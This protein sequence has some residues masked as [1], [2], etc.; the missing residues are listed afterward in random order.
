MGLWLG[1]GPSHTK[2]LEA[3]A[4]SLDT[5]LPSTLSSALSPGSVL[6]LSESLFPSLSLNESHLWSPVSL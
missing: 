2:W 6:L 1:E 5:E 4:N 3:V